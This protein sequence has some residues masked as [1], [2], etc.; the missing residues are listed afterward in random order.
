MLDSY[1]YDKALSHLGVNDWYLC[2]NYTETLELLYHIPRQQIAYIHGRR[3]S[4]DRIILGHSNLLNAEDYHYEDNMLFQDEAY[5]QVVHVANEE[6]KDTSIII[7]RFEE[8][9]NRIK[10]VNRVVV[11]GLSYGEVDLPYLE[12]IREMVVEDT[13]WYLSYYT[14]SDKDAAEEVIDILGIRKAQVFRFS[15]ADW[16]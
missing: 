8:F 9:W 5:D 11:Y 16:D 13:P 4:D 10:S 12:K 2:F 14:E 7:R 15:E 6:L 3:N 1:A